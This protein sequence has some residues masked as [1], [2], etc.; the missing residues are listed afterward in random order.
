MRSIIIAAL[1]LAPTVAF[2]QTPSP[3]DLNPGTSPGVV[4]P[5]VTEHVF[6]PEDVEGRTKRPEGETVQGRINQRFRSLITVRADF[7]DRLLQT[8][9]TL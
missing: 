4:H 8:A 5:K 9:E 3:S 6:D 7:D 1:A 2:A